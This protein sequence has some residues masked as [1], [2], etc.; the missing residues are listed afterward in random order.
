MAGGSVIR[1]DQ[2]L[3]RFSRAAPTYAAD[4]LLQQAMAWRLAQLSRRFSIRRGLWADLGSGTGHLAAALEA[5]HPEQQV[6]RIDGSAAMLSSHPNEAHTLRHDLSSGLPN[7]PEPPQLL[8]SS[9]VLHWL[10]DPAKQLR[11]WVDA[12]PER[13]WLALAVPIHG[14]FPQWHQAAR[15]AGQACT[16]LTMPVREQLIAA[17][18]DGVVQLEQCLSFS[19]HAANPLRLL[20][21]MS[22]I[23]ASVTNGGQLSPGQW[24]AVFRAWSPSDQSPGFSLTWKMLIL[25]VKR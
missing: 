25:M 14:S 22:S 16:A 24:R 18:P 10:P 8:A 2:V 4:T 12:L 1:S 15:K 6:M 17:L 7:W 5:C 13:G 11:A 9:F 23:G 3:E 21:P 20:R 19:Q